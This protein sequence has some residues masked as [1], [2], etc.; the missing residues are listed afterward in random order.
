VIKRQSRKHPKS[1]NL[2][3]GYALFNTSTV[4]SDYTEEL[5]MIIPYGNKVNKIPEYFQ[6]MLFGFLASYNS[7]DNSICKSILIYN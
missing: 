3:Q 1:A 6:K 5:P 2:R 4:K 7:V